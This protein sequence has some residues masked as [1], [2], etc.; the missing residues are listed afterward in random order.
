[1]NLFF[2]NMLMKLQLVPSADSYDYDKTNIYENS[3]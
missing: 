2:V 3:G 1:M